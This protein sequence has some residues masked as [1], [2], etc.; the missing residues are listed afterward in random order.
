MIENYIVEL[1]YEQECVIIPGFGGF[2]VNYHPAFYDAKKNVFYPPKRKVG[3]NIQLKTNDGLLYNYLVRR[4]NISFNEAREK[5]ACFVE[6]IDSRLKK[7]ET[8]VIPNLGTFI[9]KHRLVFLP[10]KEANFFAD[11]YGLDAVMVSSLKKEAV[12]VPNRVTIPVT[13]T[14]TNYRKWLVAASFL[15]SL[16]FIPHGFLNFSKYQS[17]SNLS[18]DILTSEAPLEN[19]LTE[20]PSLSDLSIRIDELSEKKSALNPFVEVK[21]SAQIVEEMTNNEILPVE[22]DSENLK[23]PEMI[24]K[25]QMPKE[26]QVEILTNKTVTENIE[27]SQGSFCLIIGSFKDKRNAERFFK[28]KQNDFPNAKFF[29][30]KGFYRITSDVFVKKTDAVKEKKSLKS[31]GV[32]S[33]IM[34]Y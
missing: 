10:D 9:F 20:H 29:Q 4:E 26:E 16:L 3:F 22:T 15:L 5:V 17:Q 2:V 18:F 14:A 1:L 25:N 33:W 8:V 13:A 12:S 11:A 19:L 27:I 28:K 30:S 21:S 34:K 32:S 24:Q 23:M 6:T 31:Q 7:K